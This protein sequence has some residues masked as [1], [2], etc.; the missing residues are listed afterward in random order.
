[1]NVLCVIPARGNSKRIPGKNIRPLLGKPLIAY[2]IEAALKDKICNKVVVSTDNADIAAVAEKYGVQ[3]IK[4]PAELSLDTS[5]L[6]D[7]LRHA[8]RTLEREENYVTD[9]VVSLYANVPIRKDG[10]IS[11]AVRKLASNDNFTAVGTAYLVSQRPEWMKKLDPKTG[12]VTSFS[13]P[14]DLYRMQDLP[15]LYLFDG[16]IFAIRKNVLM[17]T[18]NKKTAY[19]YLGDRVSLLVHEEKY[20]VEIDD[21]SQFELAEY[22]L[23][24]LEKVRPKAKEKR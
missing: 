1:M 6:D 8:V 9:I 18:E 4:R 19:A 2:T 3:V 7:A 10:E 13:G 17:E 23:R 14:T 21:E 24:K 5:A 16:A 22:Y 15:P 20:T 12:T 11:E